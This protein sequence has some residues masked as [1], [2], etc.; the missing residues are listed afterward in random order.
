MC[1][2]TIVPH[3]DGFRLVCNR[4]ER[5]DR[6]VA[7]LPMLRRLP[8]GTAIFPVDPESGGTWVGVNAAGV[9]A[10]LLN[11]AVSSSAASVNRPLRSR[12]LIIPTVLD[13]N[14]VTD[15][16]DIAT[17]LDPSQFDGFRLV[18]AQGS[19]G[20]VASSDGLTLSLQTLDV[21]RP[22]MLTSSSLGDDVVESPRR[23]LFERMMTSDRQTWLDAQGRFHAHQWPAR[24]DISIE[25]E[26]PD[27]RT[28]SRTLIHVTS[29]GIEMC[30]DALDAAEPITVRAS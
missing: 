18:V 14:S 12:G 8:H 16:L 15:A 24:A 2:V 19:V 4:D 28:V 17:R 13:C 21:S 9:A 27:A 23:R 20:G 29:Q 22:S 3:D 7:T 6:A 26:R 5:R 25:M 10:A 1:T 30:Y 11:R